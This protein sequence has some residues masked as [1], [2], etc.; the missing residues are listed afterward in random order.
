VKLVGQDVD[1]NLGRVP[2]E[3]ESA[4]E[5]LVVDIARNDSF[6][7]KH[8]GWSEV[9]F[10]KTTLPWRGIFDAFV[11]CKKVWGHH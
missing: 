8:M 4:K 5:G 9:Q 11:L 3:I 7:C 6:C 2:L 1:K 10:Q